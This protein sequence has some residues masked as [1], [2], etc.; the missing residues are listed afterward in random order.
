MCPDKRGGVDSRCAVVGDGIPACEQEE[1][2]APDAGLVQRRA[3]DDHQRQHPRQRQPTG[4]QLRQ[5]QSG[6]EQRMRPA[7]QHHRRQGQHQTQQR[8][9]AENARR[10]LPLPAQHPGAVMR[11]GGGQP[12]DDAKECATVEEHHAAANQTTGGGQRVERRDKPGQ[13]A[14]ANQC[15]Q[16][17]YQADQCQWA[18]VD[19]DTP[20]PTDGGSSDQHRHVKVSVCHDCQRW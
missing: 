17:R 14:V 4:V 9:A 13:P 1:G 3:H 15:P 18:R 19:A 20:Q 16:H 11:H 6:G 10:L 7:D 5:P 12:Q 2:A 8:Y